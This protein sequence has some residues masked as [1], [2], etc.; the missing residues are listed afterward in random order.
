MSVINEIT[1]EMF[2]EYKDIQASGEYNMLSPQAREM[3]SMDKRQWFAI[4]KNYNE[5]NIKYS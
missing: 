5:L 4:I 1:K 3:S 2:E